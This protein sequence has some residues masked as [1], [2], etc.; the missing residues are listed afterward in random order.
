MDTFDD[1]RPGEIKEALANEREMP[2]TSVSAMLQDAMRQ[3]EDYD[4]EAEK[5]SGS[6]F[7]GG[8]L[9]EMLNQNAMQPQVVEEASA[10]VVSS[11]DSPI[12]PESG[13]RPVWGRV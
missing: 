6:G 13:P 9:G 10:T 5:S 12:L 2:D 11:A 1:I 4:T 7:F 3:A 8:E